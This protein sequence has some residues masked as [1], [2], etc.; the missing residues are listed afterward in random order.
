[1]DV[2]LIGNVLHTLLCMIVSGEYVGRCQIGSGWKIQ[3]QIKANGPVDRLRELTDLSFLWI[4][5]LP[6]DYKQHGAVTCLLF[7]YPSH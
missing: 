6:K 4:S 3:K 5:R 2:Y 7:F 1:M